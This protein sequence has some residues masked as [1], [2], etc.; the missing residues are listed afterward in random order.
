MIKSSL[1]YTTW[2]F[3]A[4]IIVISSCSKE[5]E[6]VVVLPPEA[7][8]IAQNFRYVDLTIPVIDLTDQLV[9]ENRSLNGVR[10][11][12]DF[13]DGTTSTGFTGMHK[14]E[15]SGDYE[16]TLTVFNE[17]G[18]ADEITKTQRVGRR[19]ILEVFIMSSAVE[20]P[21]ELL[22]F[23]GEQDN[24][25]RIYLFS[26]PPNFS[27]NR[28]P[29]GGRIDLG[30]AIEDK[31]WFISLIENKEPFDFFDSG[32]PLINGA[33]FNPYREEPTSFDGMVGSFEVI[34]GIDVNG[35]VSNDIVYRISYR[36]F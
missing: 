8:F 32:D 36:L 24:E 16:I 14:Y 9:L 35:Q 4:L 19:Q 22:L 28:L 17:L 23:T 13:G 1:N 12:W 21:R 11:E 31:P 6:E 34:D 26:L 10:Y 7:D 25:E 15:E 33:I 2:L 30:E 3:S 18:E 20:L 29:F 27:N 5:E